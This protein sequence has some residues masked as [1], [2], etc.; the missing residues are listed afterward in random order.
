MDRVATT[1]GDSTDASDDTNETANSSNRNVGFVEEDPADAAYTRIERRSVEP[2]GNRSAV[3]F[4]AETVVDTIVFADDVDGNVTVRERTEPSERLQSPALLAF[5]VDV[6]DDS[7][8][9]SA[10]IRLAVPANVT[11][12]TDTERGELALAHRSDGEWTTLETEVVEVTDE[13]VVLEAET[14]GFSQF[15]V[16]VE[17][18]TT[19]EPATETATETATATST[20]TATATRTA[21]EAATATQSE[22][23]TPGFGPALTLL[24]IVSTALLTRR[25]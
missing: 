11:V 5:E 3:E 12:E 9:S 16:I 14:P 22:G 6:P 7:R 2:D 1:D 15:A 8:N 25:R 24:A 10:T 21:T 20:E 13:Q 17:E 4:T 19:E 23:S 18:S